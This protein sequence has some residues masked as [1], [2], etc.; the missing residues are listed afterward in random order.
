M[1]IDS[2]HQK[3]AELSEHNA[4]ADIYKVLLIFAFVVWSPNALAVFFPAER[5]TVPNFGELSKS[6]QWGRKNGIDLS[7][8]D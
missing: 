2:P 5:V 3:C 7:F 4:L 6:I 1:S 8:L